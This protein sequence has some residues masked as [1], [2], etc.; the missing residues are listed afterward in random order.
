MYTTLSQTLR[1]LPGATR[2]FP[3]HDYGDLPVSSLE[4][5]ASRNPYFQFKDSASFVAY[6]MRART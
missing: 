4:R 2:L 5:E 1:K 6:R 3:G